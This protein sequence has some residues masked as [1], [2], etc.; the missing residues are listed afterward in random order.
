M[1]LNTVCLHTKGTKN[2]YVSHI[3]FIIQC[4]VIQLLIISSSISVDLLK[5]RSWEVHKVVQF[6]RIYWWYDERVCGFKSG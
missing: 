3:H 5:G 4:V 6:L 2:G 1:Q